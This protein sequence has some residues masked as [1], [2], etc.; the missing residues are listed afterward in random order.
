MLALA[1]AE[2]L[3]AEGDLE[4]P[5]ADLELVRDSAD[6]WVNG[7]EAALRGPARA[8]GHAALRVGPARRPSALRATS[9]RPRPRAWFGLRCHGHASGD[10][11]LSL[12]EPCLG[13]GELV[14]RLLG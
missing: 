12:P 9:T 1:H 14:G 4:V 11:E 7:G 8:G 6:R 10:G 5:D 13:E 2:F 3:V